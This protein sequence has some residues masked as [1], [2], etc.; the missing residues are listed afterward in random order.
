MKVEVKIARPK[1]E[2]D[3]RCPWV[4]LGFVSRFE[5]ACIQGDFY[6]GRKTDKIGEM[7]SDRG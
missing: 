7:L 6:V 5:R 3:G 1:R 2:I 4:T